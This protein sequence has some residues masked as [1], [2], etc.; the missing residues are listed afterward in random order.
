MDR[1]PAVD[2][3]DAE[4][5]FQTFRDFA[6][7]LGVFSSVVPTLIGLLFGHFQAHH[8]P[9]PAT[10]FIL[11][12]VAGL[13]YPVC[14]R[15]GM[16]RRVLPWV[17]FASIT[18]LNL[19]VIWALPALPGG[20]RANI[21]ILILP[22]LVGALLSLPFTL[23]QTALEAGGS[24]AIPLVARATYA[25]AFPLVDYY[26]VLLPIL[27]VFVYFK[28]LLDRLFRQVQ[29]QVRTIHDLAVRDALT[30][31][32]NRRFFM[33]QGD[34][35]LRLAERGHHP[36]GLLMVDIDHFKRV[37][38]QLGHAS[39]DLVLKEVAR[40]MGATLRDT[41]LV[42][43]LG[44]EEFAIVLPDAGPGALA[45]AAERVRVAIAGEPVPL[46]DRAPHLVTLSL[47]SAQ[48]G[49]GDTLEGL[50]ARADAA[51]YRAKAEGRNRVVAG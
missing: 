18:G 38:D 31:L 9:R 39:G 8:G 1:L 14:I 26:A 27:L 2:I 10:G 48:L 30:G 11:A 36:A 50:L 19:A 33:E 4:A 45:A 21:W 25:D 6:F 13:A 44:G 12:T 17:L 51:L 3:D 40:R 20:I 24:L 32:H 42:A 34:R 28:V 5:R 15:A 35:L 47:G 16:G 37:N 41:D 46:E 22:G 49:P 29:N 43:R 23:R 7:R